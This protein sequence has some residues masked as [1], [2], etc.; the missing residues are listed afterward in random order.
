VS[1]PLLEAR[2]LRVV[3]T[4][5][6]GPLKVL[7]GASLTLARGEI[8]DVS[9]PSGSGKT[10][11]VRALALMLPHVAGELL[12]EGRPAA[13]VGPRVWRSRVALLP[14]KPA[15]FSRTVRDNLLIPWHL[16]VRHGVDAPAEDAMR[17]ALDAFGLDDVALDRDAAKLS[18]GQAARV[19]MARLGLTRPDVLLLDEPD[20]SLDEDSAALV[21]GLTVR[22]AQDGAVLR[23]RHHR[24]DGIATRR[25]RLVAGRLHGVGDSD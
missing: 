24:P 18:V 20:A 1:T 2:D 23:I 17:R 3:R 4:G 12:L 5:D 13:E 7:D 25:E 22:F 14:Q 21:A 8:V 10:T 16:K 9:G 6:A 11:L 19:A 15:I